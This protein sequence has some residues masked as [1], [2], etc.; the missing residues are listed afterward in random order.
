[1]LSDSPLHL[2]VKFP[3]PPGDVV[4]A[5]IREY[6]GDPLPIDPGPGPF[7]TSYRLP[8]EFL[9]QKADLAGE[10][11]LSV[12]LRR[13]LWAHYQRQNKAIPA[14]APSVLPA[15]VD[16]TLV[17]QKPN[18][19]ALPKGSSRVELD[20]EQVKAALIRAGFPHSI[21]VGSRYFLTGRILTLE[22]NGQVVQSWE[23][24]R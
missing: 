15:T 9:R 18:P 4:K 6:A 1:M 12:F 3:P 13:L 5:L 11:H 8:R 22:E 16:R 10:S 17:R 19:V 23:V 7:E 21:Q 2:R 14:P 20:G 24:E